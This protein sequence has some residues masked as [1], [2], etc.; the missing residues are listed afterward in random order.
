VADD[1]FVGSV[2]VGVVPDLRGFNDRL[3]AELVP[4]ANLIGRDM[5][6]EMSRGIADNLSVTKVS[7][8]KI[9][10]EIV[11]GL[12]DIKIEVGIDVTKVAIDAL[13][14]K[15]ALGLKDI[16]IIVEVDVTKVNLDAVRLKIH[17]GLS[18]IK[19][20][21]DLG[22]SN[23]SIARTRRK[24]NDGLKGINVNVGAS[25]TA[26]AVRAVGAALTPGGVGGAARGGGGFIGGIGALIERS[27][28]A[29]QALLQL[30]LR[31]LV[32]LLE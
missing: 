22:V 8:A 9:R 5:G 21:V 18:G 3:R 16:K 31:R 11:S 27:L 6:R 4:A 20:N 14:K 1:I 24:I 2:S 32:Y 23:V 19:V 17:D 29:R 12:K 26:A 25:A 13:K 28:A 7:L 15:I 30:C 10:K